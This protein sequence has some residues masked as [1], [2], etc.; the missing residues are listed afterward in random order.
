MV[1]SLDIILPFSYLQLISKQVLIKDSITIV[2]QINGK[3]KECLLIPQDLDDEDMKKRLWASAE[4][5]ACFGLNQ[6]YKKGNNLPRKKSV[7]DYQ[8]KSCILYQSAGLLTSVRRKSAR[9]HPNMAGTRFLLISA[10]ALP[11]HRGHQG[12]GKR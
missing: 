12:D 9:K 11:R 6:I 4:C 5:P 10:D 2:T 1:F 8:L 3:V 7:D